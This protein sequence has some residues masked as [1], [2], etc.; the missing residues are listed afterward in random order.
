MKPDGI[1]ER[2]S[3]EDGGENFSCH[4]FFMENPSLSGRGTAG[5]KDA[6]IL[7]KIRN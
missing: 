4:K 7:A 6:V 2:H 5:Y 3:V 1:Y